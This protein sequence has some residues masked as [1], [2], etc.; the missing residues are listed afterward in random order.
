L[1]PHLANVC[2]AGYASETA[3]VNRK[4]TAQRVGIEG[5]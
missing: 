3:T 2:E 4:Y 1:P 5:I